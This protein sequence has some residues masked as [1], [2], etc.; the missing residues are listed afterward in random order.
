MKG[1]GASPAMSELL[2]MEPAWRCKPTPES[3]S[4]QFALGRAVHSGAS[5]A[6]LKQRRDSVGRPL[7]PRCTFS[8]TRKAGVH[9]SSH[10][11]WRPLTMRGVMPKPDV[12]TAARRTAVAIEDRIRFD[13]LETG[14]L[15]APDGSVLAQ[16]QGTFGQV[17]F[18]AAE[19]AMAKD[20][21]A[22][23]NHPDGHGPS[24]EDALVG[25]QY[26]MR[27]VRVV[28]DHYRHG[29]RRLASGLMIPLHAA[30]SLEEAGAIA[31]A[32]ED[33]RKGVL[34]PAD[35]RREARHRTWLRLANRFSI[36]Y[37]RESS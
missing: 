22:T 34:T 13:T 12:S 14:V 17:G 37:W 26:G 15:I 11:S 32:R 21:T 25:A 4:A 33:V 35:F 1:W 9:A 6:R 7:A 2:A 24:L 19:Y 8:T 16:H 3:V 36:D 31:S 28:T 18:T 5:L 29:I 20:G 23:H 10:R 30:F 27:E